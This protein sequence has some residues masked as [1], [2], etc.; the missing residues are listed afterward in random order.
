MQHTVVSEP[1][2][3]PKNNSIGTVC[4]RIP[5]SSVGK[6]FGCFRENVSEDD[7][8]FFKILRG[9]TREGRLVTVVELWARSVQCVARGMRS[10]FFFGPSGYDNF[11]GCGVHLRRQLL[12]RIYGGSIFEVCTWTA[13]TTH[14][15]RRH[16]R[17]IHGGSIYNVST[18]TTSAMSLTRVAW[19]GLPTESAHRCPREPRT[20]PCTPSCPPYTPTAFTINL[21]RVILPYGESTST[22]STINLRIIDDE[23]TMDLRR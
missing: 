1:T 14:L 8:I 16:L 23:S 10:N 15:M 6:S 5:G 2:T 7:R 21:R 9:L 13:S 11:P 18:P 12:R 17:C 19:S 22:A 20:S 4:T 3:Y